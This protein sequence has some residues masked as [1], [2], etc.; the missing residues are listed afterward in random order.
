MNS[1]FHFLDMSDQSNNPTQSV[2]PDNL[3]PISIDSDS[4]NSTDTG[5][6]HE[7]IGDEDSNSNSN[8]NSNSLPQR[9]RSSTVEKSMEDVSK[10]TANSFSLVLLLLAP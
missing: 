2:F 6:N 10:N 3:E 9:T 1:F 8:T 4:D 7:V 5:S